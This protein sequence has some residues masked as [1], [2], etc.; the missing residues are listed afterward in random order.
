MKHLRAM[1]S[2]L[3]AVAL[4]ELLVTGGSVVLRS[5]RH[6]GGEQDSSQFFAYDY[7][8]HGQDWTMGACSSRSRQSPIDL[9]AAVPVTNTFSYKYNPIVEPFDLMNNGHAFSADI[10]GMGYGGITYDNAWYYLMNVNVHSLSEHSWTGLQM[11]LE[12]HLVHK[13]YDGDALLVVAIAVESPLLTGA[14]MLAAATKG[15]AFLQLNNS[16]TDISDKVWEAARRQNQ[17]PGVNPMLAGANMPVPV[18][19][20]NLQPTYVE[21]PAGDPSFNPAIQAFLKQPPP[22]VNMKVRVP[23]DSAHA[24][25]FN[26]LMQGANFYEYAGSLTAPPCAEIVT[27]LVR[28][29][30][31][32]ASD[33]QVMYLHDAIYKTTADF[34]NFRSLMPLNG[35]E[36][37]MRQGSLEEP[38]LVPAPVVHMPGQPQ[39]SDREFRAMKWAMDAMTIAKSATDYVKDLDSRLRNAAQAHANALAPQLEPLTVHGKVIVAGNAANDAVA[40]AESAVAAGKAGPAGGAAMQ[41]LE[42]QKTAE[43]MARTLANAAREEIEDATREISKKSKEVAVEAAKEA[44]NLVMSGNGNVG[45]LK[46]SAQPAPGQTPP[47]PR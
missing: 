23:A 11:P 28:Q 18:P 30:T 42:M 34:G 36:I 46:A 33:K 32:K 39:Q 22:P 17:M 16:R 12:L 35:R 21:P 13:R 15:H 26:S 41:P 3:H 6:T 29:D 19:A 27:W 40:A 43:T 4:A 20:L 44:A 31:V 1:F 25:D 2:T 14:A 8:K 38:P 5:D 45:A 7:S 37:T 47:A 10:A 9:P 24:Y